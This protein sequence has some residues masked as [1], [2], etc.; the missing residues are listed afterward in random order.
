VKVRFCLKITLFL[1]QLHLKLLHFFEFHIWTKWS[2]F[3]WSGW[4]KTR[5]TYETTDVST[6]WPKRRERLLRWMANRTLR[7]SHCSGCV[8]FLL[9][10]LFIHWLI[11]L[12]C[13]VLF[14]LLN[15]TWKTFFRCFDFRVKYQRINLEMFIYTNLKCYRRVVFIYGVCNLFI[16]ISFHFMNEYFKWNFD[17]CILNSLRLN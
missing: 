12:F 15:R 4:R 6:H 10:S 7:S 1:P 2:F 13:F 16:H 9:S 8:H 11:Q 14:C 5:E 3:C 17:I